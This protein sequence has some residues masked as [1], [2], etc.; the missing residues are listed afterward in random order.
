MPRGDEELLR[1]FTSIVK[2]TK[3]N[4]YK[5]TL[6]RFLLEYSRSAGPEPPYRV[7]YGEIAGHFVKCYWHQVYNSGL[8]QG[9][10]SQTPLAIA[11]IRAEFG[12]RKH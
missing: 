6:A 12:D 5:L 10:K 1:L 8:R 3:N 11:I 4:T 7:S 2:G 9:P